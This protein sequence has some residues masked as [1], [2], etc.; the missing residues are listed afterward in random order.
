MVT[1]PNSASV[2]SEGN[3]PVPLH[4]VRIAMAPALL[5]AG[6]FYRFTII[7]DK[8][9]LENHPG[10]GVPSPPWISVLWVA[11]PLVLY[12]LSWLLLSAR[13][14]ESI[15]AGAGV[16]AGLFTCGLVFAITV[17]AGFLLGFGL[18]PD[19]YAFQN[20]ISILTFLACSLWIIVS[21]FRIGKVDWGI[22]LL[23]ASSTL[24]CVACL[25]AKTG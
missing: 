13:S 10:S 15:A 6:A 7:P 16:A 5:A 1:H 22:F 3:R 25:T 23:A 11:L 2:E 18:S 14:E 12:V 8:Q 21:G 19:P 17:L 20:T 24:I 4:G 9:W